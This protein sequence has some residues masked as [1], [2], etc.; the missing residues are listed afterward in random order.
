MPA[1]FGCGKILAMIVLLFLALPA[2][3]QVADGIIEGSVRDSLSGRPIPEA[4]LILM[5]PGGGR[6]TSGAAGS[7][8]FT[9]LRPGAY[10]VT[11][12]K[13]GYVDSGYREGPSGRVAVKSGEVALLTIELTPAGALEG[14]VTGEDGKPL[15][16]ATVYVGRSFVTAIPAETGE[17]GYFRVENLA[18]GEYRLHVR[19]P[20]ET[21][22]KTARR[23]PEHGEIW[24]YPAA[25]EAPLAAYV[26]PGLTVRGFQVQLRQ[27]RVADVAGRLIDAAVG[28]PLRSAHVELSGANRANDGAFAPRAAGSDGRFELPLVEPGEYRLLVYYEGERK[29]WPYVL[30]LSVTP[31]K[32]EEQTFRVPAPVRLDGRVLRPKDKTEPI[33]NLTVKI[34][35]A[36]PGARVHEVKPGADGAFELADVPPGDYCVVALW[37]GDHSRGWYVDAIRFGSQEGVARPLRIGE[38]G[39]PPVEIVLGENGGRIAGRIPAGKAG[40]PR[41]FLILMRRGPG[42]L[43]A[44][45]ALTIM[46][47]PDGS[48]SAEDLTPG[49]YSVQL[50]GCGKSKL[51]RVERGRTSTVEIDE[52]P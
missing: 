17:G 10:T 45:E 48:F 40:T 14:C 1:A 27:V 42:S 33:S 46:A 30:P 28:G 25:T 8:R 38:A 6:T 23:I 18:P 43:A 32:A 20:F 47:Q 15:S 22:Q 35:P 16:G 2:L 4:A 12:R 34:A 29:R 39:N 19:L 51:V 52:C 11:V 13:A 3:A 26:S 50:A 36:L 31:H 37:T 9:G 41:G 24:A 21:R 5:G 49:E 44:L 7:F